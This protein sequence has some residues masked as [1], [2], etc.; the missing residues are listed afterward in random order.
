MR[1]SWMVWM[2]MMNSLE[3]D[4]QV[5]APGVVEGLSAPC[6]LLSGLIP[7]HTGFNGVQVGKENGQLVLY[8]AENAWAQDQRKN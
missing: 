3:K 4:R 2:R 1:T 8:M 5:E 6:D 7:L